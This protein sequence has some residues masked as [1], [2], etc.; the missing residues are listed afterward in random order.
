MKK[1]LENV[2][3]IRVD[4]REVLNG[5][6]LVLED[7]KIVDMYPSAAGTASD[8]YIMPGFTDSHVHLICEDN[9]NWYV[10]YGVTSVYNMMGMP[11]H[12]RWQQEIRQGKRVGPEIISSGPIIDGTPAYLVSAANEE[13]TQRVAA[14]ADYPDLLY[15]NG[16][17][18]ADTP[19]KGRRAVRYTKDVGYQFVKIYN[20]LDKDVYYAI[21][22]EAEK[23]GIIVSGHLPDCCNPDTVAPEEA[24]VR[25]NVVEHI[26][27]ISDDFIPLLI[28]NGSA[29]SPTLAVEKTLF[30]NLPEQDFYKEAVEDINELIKEEWKSAMKKHQEAAI[31][32]RPFRKF[33]PP[34]RRSMQED[35]RLVK[36]MEE[37][38][39]LLM[40]GTDSGIEGTIPG[41]SLHVEIDGMKE[42]GLDNWT[43][44]EALTINAEKAYGLTSGK[45]IIAKDMP[46]DFIVLNGNP[47]EKIEVLHD[48]EGLYY[49][50]QH[51]DK[52]QLLALRRVGKEKETLEFNG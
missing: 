43:I 6:D 5:Y 32:A 28:K 8:T 42:A 21:C 17:I 50:D 13:S 14:D 24:D 16:I 39:V 19:E 23:L 38:G 31:A 34:K 36:K 9:L 2:N 35:Y 33:A 20:N 7:G 27:F 18:V 30:D 1:T 49:R 52:E 26:T 22:D 40:T 15:C 44:L 3:I 12:L 10:A 37:A 48:I 45:G 25:Q 51:F 29:N 46:A 47:L 11:S 4:Q 41:F